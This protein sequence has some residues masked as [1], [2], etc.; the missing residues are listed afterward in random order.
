[1]SGC[2]PDLAVNCLFLFSHKNLAIYSQPLIDVFI[3]CVLLAGV[4]D[5]ATE[6]IPRDIN[7]LKNDGRSFG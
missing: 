2:A 6:Y 4:R 5:S 7:M 1:M 3:C